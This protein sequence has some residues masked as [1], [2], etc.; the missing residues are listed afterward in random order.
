VE[1]GILR[2]KSRKVKFRLKN[3]KRDEEATSKGEKLQF[4]TEL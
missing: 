4:A 1:V 2:M 3:I